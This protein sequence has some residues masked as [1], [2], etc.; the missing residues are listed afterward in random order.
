[1]DKFRI[2]FR[3]Q[4]SKRLTTRDLTGVVKY[5]ILFEF[6][7]DFDL[8]SL[9]EKLSEFGLFDSL[10][11]LLDTASH[12]VRHTFVSNLDKILHYGNSVTSATKVIK[13]YNLN[14]EHYPNYIE[15][16]STEEV[17]RCLSHYLRYAPNHEDHMPLDH[18]EDR[19]FG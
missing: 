19:C 2:Y 8:V 12:E 11:T 7:N 6:Q 4:A 15:K 18:V 10:I 1:M 9:A 16:I 5:I 13:E 3:A 17:D 14:P